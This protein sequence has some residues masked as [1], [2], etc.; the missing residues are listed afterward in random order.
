MAG[1][2]GPQHIL[3]PVDTERMLASALKRMDEETHA[4]AQIQE[5]AAG[6]EADYRKAKGM[7][8]IAIIKAAKENNWSAAYRDARIDVELDGERR[9]HLYAQA[10]LHSARESLISIRTRVEALRTISA[11]VRSQV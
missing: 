8:A 11:S 5:Y 4:F 9:I 6:S 7:K 2:E 10:S 3:T 1:P